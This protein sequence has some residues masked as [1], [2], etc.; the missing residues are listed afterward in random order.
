[1]KFLKWIEK[2]KKPKKQP[3]L[4]KKKP[5]KQ[6]ELKKKKTPVNTINS[7]NDKV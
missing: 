5:K 2:K 3:E 4:K 6:P 1:M 7:F